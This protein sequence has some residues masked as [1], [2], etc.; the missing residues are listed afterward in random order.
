VEFAVDALATQARLKA[1]C[2]YGFVVEVDAFAS[3]FR[4]GF[5]PGFECFKAP[6]SLRE[7]TGTSVQHFGEELQTGF[8]FRSA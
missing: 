1:F 2:D 8:G 6:F 5:C 4:R 3:R 7:L